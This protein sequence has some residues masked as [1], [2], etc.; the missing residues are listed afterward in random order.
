M[1][2]ISPL[3]TLILSCAGGAEERVSCEQGLLQA[4]ALDRPQEVRKH[5]PCALGSH[6][7]DA[8]RAA[9]AALNAGLYAEKT[10][11][12]S[13]F[14]SLYERQR[15]TILAEVVGSSDRE[16]IV[17]GL[18]VFFEAGDAAALWGYIENNTTATVCFDDAGQV[19]PAMAATSTVCQAQAYLAQLAKK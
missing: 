13:D 2:G 8:V 17:L 7:P 9:L 19:D 6:D 15:G 4:V 10:T 3:L 14:K 11:G 18:R 5:L 12:S 1:T 16:A